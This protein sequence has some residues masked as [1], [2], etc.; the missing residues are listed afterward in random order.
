M[1]LERWAETEYDLG[2]S[3]HSFGLMSSLIRPLS[4]AEISEIMEE[5]KVFGSYNALDRYVE[6]QQGSPNLKIMITKHSWLY[7]GKTATCEI[8]CEG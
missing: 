4:Q 5:E 1:S 2:M 3:D 7:G 6:E 8:G